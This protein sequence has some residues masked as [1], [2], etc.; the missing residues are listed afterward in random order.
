MPSNDIW[1]AALA[2][3]DGL[4]VLTYDAHFSA[5]QRI[6]VRLLEQGAD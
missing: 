6:G 4:P 5:I 2:A 3:R 1:I